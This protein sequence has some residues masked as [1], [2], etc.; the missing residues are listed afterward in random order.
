MATER[1]DNIQRILDEVLSRRP[2]ERAAYLSGACGGNTELCAE[3]ESLLEHHEAATKGCFMPTVQF[4]AG[5]DGRGREDP[6]CAADPLVGTHVGPYR[7][8]RRIGG[9]GM[10]TVY[11]AL[12]ERPRRPVALK[13]MRPGTDLDRFVYESQTLARLPHPSIAQ[14]YDAGTHEG[15]S[16]PVPYFTME[17]VPNAKSITDYV[18]EWKLSV[19]EGLEM[20]AKVCDA[21]SHAHLKGII[22]RDIKPSNIVVG[23]SGQ[24]K[25]IDFGLALAVDWDERCELAGTLQYMSPEQVDGDPRDLDPRTDVYSLGLVI[26][27]L[28]V[29]RL[30]YDLAG[31]SLEDARRIIR[32]TP[33]AAPS[34]ANPA[35]GP[36]VDRIVLKALLKRRDRRYRSAA[37]ISDALRHTF[38]ETQQSRSAT[39]VRRSDRNT[40]RAA[41]GAAVLL[42]AITAVVILGRGSSNEVPG[43]ALI[44]QGTT[45]I[46]PQIPTLVTRARFIE[47]HWFGE[48][49]FDQL[50]DEPEQ[51]GPKNQLVINLRADHDGYFYLFQL[52]PDGRATFQPRVMNA[53]ECVGQRYAKATESIDHYDYKLTSEPSGMYC[54]V[55]VLADK[56][57]PGICRHV[58]E[59]LSSRERRLP[60]WPASDKQSASSV[61]DFLEKEYGSEILGFDV[62]EYPV[63]RD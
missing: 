32:E 61:A 23:G 22:H 59:G 57:L 5:E 43:D 18:R 28:V 24:P 10:G 25:L 37:E 40:K 7:I 47:P 4:Q 6:G 33:P 1:W 17:Y 2:E 15:E 51:P 42:L 53:A 36:D 9:G 63:Y 55:A 14:V 21:L 16:G 11:E 8:E 62:Y 35:V 52:G 30:P 60:S 13:I 19:P 3:V 39:K 41:A 49:P 44:L 38:K 45:H 26:Y 12:Q 54:F 29:G 20:V 50:P 48:N 34:E 27:E 58:E 31:A 56:E 46:D